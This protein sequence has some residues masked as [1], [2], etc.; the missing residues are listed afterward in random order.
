MTVAAEEERRSIL[1]DH[2]GQALV[3]GLLVAFVGFGSSFAVVLQGL[4][5][6]G[7]TDAEAA[8]GLMAAGV[9]MG[10]A[11]IVL[12]FATRQPISCAWS[13]PGAAML[14]GVA[15]A[16][17]SIVSFPEAVGGFV[18]C[19]VLIVLSGLVRPLGR[20]VAA[21]PAPL[22]NAMLAG[23]LLPLCLASFR[24]IDAYPAMGLAILAGFVGGG[25]VN[26]LLAVPAALFAFVLAITF[27]VEFPAGWTERIAAA[28][29]PE[30]VLTVPEFTIAGALSVGLPLYVVTMASQNIP[31]L[32][33]LN[34]HGYRPVTGPLVAAT[35]IF[36]LAGTPFGSHAVNLAAITAAMCAGEEAHA[37]P[38]RR[39]WAAVWA[40][41]FYVLFSLSAGAVVAFVT[42]APTVLI[43]AVAGVAL[44]GAFTGAAMAAFDRPA[45]RLPCAVTFL[46]TAS[47]M[48]LLSVSGAF[49]GLV[50]GGLV[51]RLTVLEDV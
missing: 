25:L 36:S 9:G 10:L 37:D 27:G 31:G 1:R 5:A 49:W 13:T 19:G 21:I 34:L 32:A 29:P 8:S 46:A 17:V 51:W 14:A 24:A 43:E 39:Y 2:S 28:F 20:L 41:V 42:L 6:V 45:H 47:G 22:A 4:K 3:M 30:P 12:S 11:G 35:G 26:R 40:G 15:A 50:L 16:G 48:T 7:A 44:F 33:V 38:A 18:L 23:V